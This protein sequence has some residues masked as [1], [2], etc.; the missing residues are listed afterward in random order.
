MR[1]SRRAFGYTASAATLA[2]LMG[3]ATAANRNLKVGVQYKVD[4]LA[5]QGTSQWALVEYGVAETLTVANPDGSVVGWLAKS[6]DS[7]DGKTWTIALRDNVKFQ[8]GRP[9]TADVVAKALDENRTLNPEGNFMTAA[10]ITAS[11]PLQITITLDKPSVYVPAALAGRYYFPIYDADSLPAD[12]KDNAAFL[13]A[14]VYTGPFMPVEVPTDTALKLAANP[15]YWRGAVPTPGIEIVVIPSAETR[16]S[17]V[18]SGDIDLATEPPA[19]AA[20]KFAAD[21]PVRL[22]RN[23][24]SAGLAPSMIMHVLEGPMTDV[25]VRRA[26]GYAIDYKVLAHDVLNDVYLPATGL[27]GPAIGD[28]KANY[29]TD[30]AKAAALLEEAGWKLADGKRMK[31]GKPLQLTYLVGSDDSDGTNIGV[32]IQQMLAEIGVELSIQ[33]VADVYAAESFPTWHMLVRPNHTYGVNGSPIDAL[34]YSIGK[35]W[36]LGGQTDAEVAQLSEQ[37]TV[38]L[39]PMARREILHK[40][41]DRVLDQ[42]LLYALAFQPPLAAVGADLHGFVPLLIPM[43]PWDIGA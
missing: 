7:T 13:S 19:S 43:V 5:P 34:G 30:P 35:E 40:L 26:I 12:Q 11:G 38:T 37:A 31:D 23:P 28:L 17:A 2:A 20:L 8:N 39:D 16:I 42:G 18:E 6:V 41:Q 10:K 21:G 25:R 24:G 4:S 27:Y 36:G 3:R 15:N 32:A 29:V 14:K 1:F 9:M 22:V 33:T